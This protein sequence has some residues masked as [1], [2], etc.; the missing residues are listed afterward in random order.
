MPAFGL[1]GL[2]YFVCC[3]PIPPKIDSVYMRSL[4]DGFLSQS[5]GVYHSKDICPHHYRGPAE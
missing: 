5:T 2:K 3:H 4:F 1:C